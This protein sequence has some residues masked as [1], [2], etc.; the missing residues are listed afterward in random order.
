METAN[1]KQEYILLPARGLRARL[2]RSPAASVLERMA[3]VSSLGPP[4]R[5]A[6]DDAL[7]VEVDVVDSIRD[8]GPKLVEMTEEQARTLRRE[9]IGMRVEPLRRYRMALVAAPKPHEPASGVGG[10]ALTL[11]VVCARSGRPVEGA[12]VSAFTDHHAGR[13]GHGV[14][15]AR[16]HVRLRLGG[17]AVPLDR[18]YVSPPPSGFWGR[19]ADGVALRDGDRLELEP[20]QLPYPDAVRWRYP[21][22][23]GGEGAGIRVGVIDT[24]VSHPDLV[25]AGG[26][27]TV[28]GEP[29]DDY[30]D[31]GHGHGT[32]VAGIIAARG[33]PPNGLL[34]LAPGAELHSYRVFGEGSVSATN[35]AIVKALVFAVDE[36]CDLVNLSLTTPQPDEVVRDA[37]ADAVDH[38]V[39]VLAAAGN[40]GRQPVAVPAAYE[41][42]VAV[43][44]MGRKGAFPTGCYHESEVGDPS[45]TDPDSFVAAFSN[46]GR[47]VDLI[48]PGVGV[49]STVPGGYGPMSGTSMACPAVAGI[50]ARLLSQDPQFAQLPRDRDRMRYMWRALSLTATPMGVGFDY[51]GNGLL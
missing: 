27:N 13:G 2:D 40:D 33:T 48:A 29:C 38:G 14:S 47:D 36:G 10:G 7:P 39:L 41:D 30:G 23:Q 20:V 6:P 50:A 44:A 26:R 8:D 46:F 5:L 34:G 9:R 45:G 16:G 35:Y 22:A 31:N 24:G 51:E 19:Y 18:L 42:A 25:V 37:I 17:T 12:E 32:H 4:R 11:E 28:R 21:P 3:G 43:T 1:P 49:V 15:D